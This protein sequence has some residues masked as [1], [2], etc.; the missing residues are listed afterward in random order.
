MSRGNNS[1][2]LSLLF[3]E[4]NNHLRNTETKY[5]TI[6]ISY[7]SLVSVI[8]S[9]VFQKAI[10][11]D[12]NVNY[13]VV[14]I[15]LILIGT[16]VITLQKWDRFW[17][18]HYLITAQKIYSEI[19]AIN[20][21]AISEE[22]KPYWLREKQII[23]WL[24]NEVTDRDKNQEKPW[25]SADYTLH[26]FTQIVNLGVVLKLGYDLFSSNH[27]VVTKFVIPILIIVVYL[28]FITFIPPKPS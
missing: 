10:I 5:L 16:S 8:S 11:T 23:N 28:L 21:I 19:L 4:I 3:S 2:Y 12:I 1:K 18:E 22:L 9:I 15:L 7:L 13:L 27:S 25:L 6:S 14:Y 26:F 24:N 17:K 20:Q